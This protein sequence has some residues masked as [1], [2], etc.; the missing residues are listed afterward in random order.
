MT[1]PRLLL[2]ADGP[3]AEFA[4]VT[5][6]PPRPAPLVV[7][8]PPEQQQEEGQQQQ[9]SPTL[10]GSPTAIAAGLAALGVHGASLRSSLGSPGEVRLLKAA[11]RRQQAAEWIT[12]QT[13]I[14]VPH[15]TD[16][17]FR[18]A[19]RDG[20]TLCRLLNALRP[21]AVPKVRWRR[22]WAAWPRRS[23]AAAQ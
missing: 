15:D 14:A 7:D 13:G 1:T 2:Q 11:A 17:A 6:P 8:L 4:F 23:V 16:A 5:P 18:Q 3:A 19:L 20:V 9:Q 21:G 22:R 12:E 10:V